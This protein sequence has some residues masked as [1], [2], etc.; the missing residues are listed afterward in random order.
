MALIRRGILL[1]CPSAADGKTLNDPKNQPA[2]MRKGRSQW[3]V[4]CDCN[5]CPFCEWGYNY[6]VSSPVV[7]NPK[8]LPRFREPLCCKPADGDHPT[9]WD[10]AHKRN[11]GKCFI[12]MN[13][14]KAQNNARPK[15]ERL[16]YSQLEREAYSS[17]KGC[18]SCKGGQGVNI[19]KLHWAT[20]DHKI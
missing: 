20:F 17:K 4:P 6:G 10:T 5:E 9:S 1:D 15:S 2:Y 19:C 18:K 11:Q 12:C 14:L 7:R 13:E 3:P 16:K 8:S